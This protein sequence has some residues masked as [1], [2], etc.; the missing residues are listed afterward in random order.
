MGL[1]ISHYLPLLLYIAGIVSAFFSLLYAPAAGFFFLVP[2]LPYT[3]VLEKLQ[4]YFWGKNLPNILFLCV[5]VGWFFRRSNREKNS[6]CKND[7]NRPVFWLVI[8]SIIGFAN[9][10][11]SKGMDVSYIVD[12]KDYM[13]LPLIW[14]LTVQVMKDKKTLKLFTLALIIGIIGVNYY[15]FSNLKWMDLTHFSYKNRDAFMGIFVYLGA[16]HYGAF[17]VHFF[18]I[19]MGF[20]LFTKSKF[21]K[22]G[23]V[24]IISLSVYNIMY[25]YSRGAYLAL[26]A[27]LF[28]LGLMKERKI[29]VLL[30]VFLI[31]WKSFAPVSVIERIEMT[32]SDN[33]QLEESAAERVMLWQKAWDMFLASPVIGEGFNTFEFNG[34]IDTHNYYLKMLAEEGVIGLVTFLYVLLSALKMSWKLYRESTDDYFRAIGLGFAL[35]VVSVLITNFF[36]NRWS[37]LS[38]GAYFWA[39]MGIMTRSY[40]IHCGELAAGETIERPPEQ[41]PPGAVR[42]AVKGRL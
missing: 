7:L 38:L 35:C 1:G 22:I 39:F 13:F 42:H 12:W 14:L 19:L 28:F 6:D 21:Q 23:L 16:N 8:S 36:G 18:F 37:Y 25:S 33:G 2:L 30:A 34:F 9:G 11:M 10:L 27:G 29:L 40:L 5:I 15:Y 17:F 3:S 20:L 4:P 41:V 31:F 26:F 24:I 32:R